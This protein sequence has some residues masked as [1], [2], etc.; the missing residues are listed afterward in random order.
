MKTRTVSSLLLVA[1]ALVLPAPVPAQV[2][3]EA[4][5][6]Y[7][8]AAA[9]WGPSAGGGRYLSRWAEDWGSA[10]R[11]D[12]T[13]F[14]KAIALGGDAT[15]SLSAETRLRFNAYDDARLVAGADSS[16]TW[17]RGVLGADLRLDERVR[18]YTEL[19]SGAVVAGPSSSSPSV[20]NELA[21]NQAFVDLSLRE[22]TALVGAMIGRQEFAD[23]PRQLMSVSDGPNLHRSWNGLRFY[24]H[25]A[26]AR[27]G[28]FW[29][30]ATRLGEHAFDDDVDSDERLRGAN[31]SIELRAFERDHHAFLDPFWFHSDLPEVALQGTV[32]DERR[33]TFGLRLWGRERRHGFDVTAAHQFGRHGDQGVQAWA[34]FAG[35]DVRLSDASWDPRATLGLDVASGGNADAGA[36]LRTFHPLYSSSSYLGEGRLLALANLVRIAPGVSVSPTPRTRVSLEYGWAWRFAPDDAAYGGGF[37]AYPGTAGLRDHEIGQL[38]RLESRWNGDV[39]WSIAFGLEHLRPSRSLRDAGLDSGSYAFLSLTYRH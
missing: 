16:E 7:P 25:G 14:G 38:V 23:G 29:L 17:W 12:A 6:P 26:R 35:Y 30:S 32:E 28:A 34:L 2:K 33:D 20:S 21:L 31:G 27:F 19:A 4:R 3:P 5:G 18:V 10:S 11:R 1:S 37:R 24:A 9:G 15:L 22:G 39:G 13:P 8:A 36:E